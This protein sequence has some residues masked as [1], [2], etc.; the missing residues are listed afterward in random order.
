VAKTRHPHRDQRVRRRRYTVVI[1]LAFFVCLG[2]LPT[3]L[4]ALHLKIKAAPLPS[5][6]RIQLLPAPSALSSVPLPPAARPIDP[7]QRPATLPRVSEAQEAAAV[8][9]QDNWLRAML[10]ASFRS[11]QPTVVPYRGSLPTLILTSGAPYSSGGGLA[12]YTAPP[13]TYTAADLVQYGALA[14]LPHGAALLEDNIFVAS[15]AQLDLSSANVRAVYLDNT[16]TGPASIVGWQ[17]GL[18]FR[19]TARRPLTIAGWDEATMTPARDAGHGRPYIREVAGRMT[20]A[21]VRVSSLGFWSGRTGGVA[22]T[23]LADYPSTGGATSTTFTGNTYGAF[24]TQSHDIRFSADLFESNQLDGLHIH[25]GTVGASATLSSAV[26]NGENGFHVDRGANGTVLRDD[27]AQHNATNGFLADGRP[28]VSTASPSGNAVAPGSG[29]RIENSAAVGNGETGILVEGGTGMVLKADEVCARQTGIALRYGASNTIVDGNDVRCNPRV[30]LSI[31]PAAPVTLV[32][33]NAVSG[34]R[35]AVL[36][37]SSG[38]VA[39]DNSLITGATVFGISVRGANSVVS[40]RDNVISGT[41]FRAVDARADAAP[42]ALSGSDTAHWAYHVKQTILTY[43]EFHPLAILWLSIV[44]LVTVGALWTRRRRLSA[45]PYP[46]STRWTGPEDDP[47]RDAP[48]LVA[49]AR[50]GPD[51]Q[52][53]AGDHDAWLEDTVPQGRGL[54]GPAMPDGRVPHDRT[55][56]RVVPDVS[57]VVPDI[58]E[59]DGGPQ[60]SLHDRA[61]LIGAT[62]PLA[63]VDDR[64]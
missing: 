29:T 15:G 3:I 62:S 63:R 17:G 36:V 40:G 44:F 18:A 53:W 39:M 28:L 48:V 5:S 10:H 37:R 45:H 46:E 25:R 8:S 20:L 27:V 7:G 56:A 61:G 1:A 24:V 55:L 6:E 4:S 64:P 38:S 11:Y 51:G 19:G 59:A 54:I 41:G 60:M 16:P 33:G 13:V 35:I 31:G 12:T 50:G 14:P 43:L 47:G 9:A 58:R 32:S 30:G 23:G 34:A 57:D 26:R 22:W 2:G 49:A 21:N 42:P 52:S